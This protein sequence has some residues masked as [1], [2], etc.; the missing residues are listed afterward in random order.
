MSRIDD[1]LD[2]L[3]GKV[4]FSTLDAKRGYW[5]IRVHLS[6]QEKTAFVTH[7]ELYEFGI[8]PFGL[9]NT[10]EVDAKG[11]VWYE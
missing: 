6:S 8:M 9:C 7:D 5:Q 11:I 2:L 10:P 1:L 3:K 4:I